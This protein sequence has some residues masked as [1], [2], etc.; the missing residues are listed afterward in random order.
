MVATLD[1]R[2]IFRPGESEA[3][4]EGIDEADKISELISIEEA[5][6]KAMLNRE[7]VDEVVSTHTAERTQA[8]V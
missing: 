8:F 7:G 4:E 6:H 2:G 1:A 3:W 5:L